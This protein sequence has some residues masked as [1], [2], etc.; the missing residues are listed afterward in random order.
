LAVATT[1]GSENGVPA[2]TGATVVAGAAAVEVVAAF[3]LLVVEAA[4]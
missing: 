2:A 1:A 3:A 4:R